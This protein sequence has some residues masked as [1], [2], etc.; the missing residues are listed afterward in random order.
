M[1]WGLISGMVTDGLSCPMSVPDLRADASG[2]DIFEQRMAQ[3]LRMGCSAGAW[4]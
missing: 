2:G 3:A 4:Q 1:R